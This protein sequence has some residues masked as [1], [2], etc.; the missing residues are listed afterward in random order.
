MPGSWTPL[1]GGKEGDDGS[2]VQP[3]VDA[4]DAHT[5]TDEEGIES[6]LLRR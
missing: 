5:T 4:G 3:Q 1:E 2:V 6:R